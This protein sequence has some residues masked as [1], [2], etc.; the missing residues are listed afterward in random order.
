MAFSTWQIWVFRAGIK[1]SPIN[2]FVWFIFLEIWSLCRTFIEIIF[3]KYLIKYFNQTIPYCD[4]Y[5]TEV[6]IIDKIIWKTINTDFRKLAEIYKNVPLLGTN[7][8]RDITTF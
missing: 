6:L 2:K 1:S 7:P 4:Q 3:C 5:F 8:I